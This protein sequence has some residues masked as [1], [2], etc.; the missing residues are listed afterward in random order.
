MFIVSGKN[1]SIKMKHNLFSIWFECK[2]DV[3][4]SNFR[5][6]KSNQIE[7]SYNFLKFSKNADLKA[8]LQLLRKGEY[9]KRK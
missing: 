8:R 3:L 5:I 9:F 1:V 2:E 4:L 7:P 6:E